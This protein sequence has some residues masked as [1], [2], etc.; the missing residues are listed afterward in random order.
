MLWQSLALPIAID[1][2]A[3]S[4]LIFKYAIFAAAVLVKVLKA[5]YAVPIKTGEV[6]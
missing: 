2:N 4:L 1:K 3:F 5:G 6:A